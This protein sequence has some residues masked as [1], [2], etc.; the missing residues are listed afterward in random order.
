MWYTFGHD[1]L[2]IWRERTTLET[3][4]GPKDGL[5]SLLPFKCHL[6]EV[7]SVGDWLNICPWVASRVES[8][9]GRGALPPPS[10]QTRQA[11]PESG[12]DL[13]HF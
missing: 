10:P 2:Q 13:I 5:F 7:A 11:R 12:L 8:R 4:Q 6:P 3:T 9:R 1:A